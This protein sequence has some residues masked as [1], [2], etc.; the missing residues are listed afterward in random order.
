MDAR[1]YGPSVLVGVL[2]FLLAGCRNVAPPQGLLEQQLAGANLSSRKLRALLTDYVP[3]FGEQVEEAADMILDQATDAEV[4]KN[5]LLWKTN[6]I[7]ACFRAAARPDPLA[8]YLDT[9]ILSRQMT[10]LFE[11]P[12]EKPLF[13]P[14]QGLAL[15]TA[16]RLEE[17]LRQI[18]ASLGQGLPLGE[19]FVDAF[20][21]DYPVTSLYFDRES[22]AGRYI[23]SVDEP[24]R[25]ML[26]VAS[27]LAESVTE[28]RRLSA[29]YAE[30]L[31][32]QARWQ[33][34][35][36][37][38]AATETQP[39]SNSLHDL[40]VAS[41]AID[42][43]AD[44]AA[45]LPGLLAR[46]RQALQ[47]I[48]QQE[49][50]ETVAQVDEMRRE[51]VRELQHERA[52][53]LASLREER[54]EVD[55]SLRKLADRSLQQLDAMTQQRLEGVPA[56]GNQLIDYAFLR[57]CDLAALA[58]LAL[59]ACVVLVALVARSALRSTPGSVGTGPRTARTAAV[60][61]SPVVRRR[62]A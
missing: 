35:L 9:W 4:R 28:L 60:G 22:L 29:L 17:P 61:S 58:G 6:S 27:G 14:G 37:L 53:V 50:T 33:S 55:A 21:R 5:A 31:P 39:V 44:E 2:M 46:E 45:T 42:R 34:E 56:V 41:R 49:R 57:V 59:L 47:A 23:Q 1:R 24:T 3:R 10:R 16:R 8:A 25:E 52:V 26:D 30:F 54:I 51:T 32:K 7:S 18:H 13:G 62:T 20:A 36:L 12:G 19:D 11:R 43:M 15:D 48:V 40:T 38:I